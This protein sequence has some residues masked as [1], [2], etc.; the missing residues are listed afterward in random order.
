MNIKTG[1]TR[2]LLW[3][4]NRVK[5]ILTGFDRCNRGICYIENKIHVL[6]YCFNDWMFHSISLKLW[7][8]PPVP[9]VS[10]FG[11]KDGGLTVVIPFNILL[12]QLNFH[13]KDCFN[14]GGIN[15]LLYQV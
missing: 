9:V 15:E 3:L 8:C 14:P 1:L 5:E 4:D 7:T 13:R 12:Y 10:A 11:I 2:P 6:S